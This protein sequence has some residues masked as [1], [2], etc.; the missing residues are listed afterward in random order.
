MREKF[1]LIG[2]SIVAD[3]SNTGTQP[4][5]Q[6]VGQGPTGRVF[7]VA[8][9]QRIIVSADL[10]VSQTAGST[11]YEQPYRLRAKCESVCL[12][13]GVTG[14]VAR[15]ASLHAPATD[16]KAFGLKSSTPNQQFAT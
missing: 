3:H 13:G 1:R 14:G 6:Q 10:S 9:E 2:W 11:S 7:Q 16:G 12:F 8:R 15:R 5:R 4:C